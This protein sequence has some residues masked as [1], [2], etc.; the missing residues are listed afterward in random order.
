VDI[1]GITA[2]GGPS[3]AC[4]L[5]D[6]R[7]IAAASEDRFTRVSRDPA[8][9]RNAVSFCL[10]AGKIGPAGVSFAA[11][12]GDPRRW[13]R[14]EKT[15][16]RDSSP[17]AAPSFRDRIRGWFER[18]EPDPISCEL[19]PSVRTHAVETTLAHA[20]AA[21]Y[22]SPF[23][24]AA[25]LVLLPGRAALATGRGSD[26]EIRPGALDAGSL[27][28]EGDSEHGFPAEPVVELAQHVR[29]T[30]GLTSLALGGPLAGNPRLVGELIRARIF[31]RVWSHPACSAGAEALGAAL[32]FW[33]A[34]AEPPSARIPSPRF[35][36]ALGPGYNS[37]QIRT[38]LR[39][40]DIVPEEIPREALA[41]HTASLLADGLSVGWF[42]GRLDFG[43]ETITTRSIVSASP[44]SDFPPDP[45][46]VLVTSTDRCREVLQLS[47]EELPP[48]GR[49]V[50]HDEWARA[51]AG[52]EMPNPPRVV[53]LVDRDEDR[54]F[55]D[56]LSAFESVTGCSALVARSLRQ[57]GDPVV[58]T[59]NDAFEVFRVL[60]PDVMVMGLYLFRSETSQ[61]A[62][63]GVR[64]TGG[65]R[66]REIV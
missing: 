48:C 23:S 37:H 65:G 3:A 28:S 31:E 40:Q 6:G 29:E 41:S 20:A 62:R 53:F 12:A 52:K 14:N 18:R 7:V 26:L 5:R 35:P 56:L 25:I 43:E 9:P 42:G 33:H 21:F 2:F 4:L 30:T 8:F 54:L 66:S 24:D 45:S 58:C 15:R 59:P 60:D 50:L 51:L 38:F 63:R 34:E 10:R 49:G 47:E 27:G 46:E 57:P 32:H 19:D 17:G 64:L 61:R 44:L 39:S 13:P 16:Y 1:V 36:R 11:A 22:P 55:H